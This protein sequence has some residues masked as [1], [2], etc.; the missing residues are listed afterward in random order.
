MDGSNCIPFGSTSG[1]R[2]SDWGCA[3]GSVSLNEVAILV[4]CFL[5]FLIKCALASSQLEITWKWYELIPVLRREFSLPRM[6]LV[7]VKRVNVW[8][9]THPEKGDMDSFSLLTASGC[10]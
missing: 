4:F 2:W 5:L 3:V 7:I 1:G 10:L 8:Y 9:H 6:P